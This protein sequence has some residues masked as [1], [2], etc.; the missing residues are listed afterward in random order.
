MTRLADHPDVVTDEIWAE[1]AEHY[2][3]PGLSALVS[4]VALTNYDRAAIP[5]SAN[6]SPAGDALGEQEARHV[7][8]WLT[9][10]SGLEDDSVSASPGVKEGTHDLCPVGIRRA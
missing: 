4:M 6:G 5:R 7:G 9:D 8:T 3:E 2:D 1:T 10:L